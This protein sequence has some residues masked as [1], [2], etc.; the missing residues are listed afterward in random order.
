MA[1]AVMDV[2]RFELGLRIPEDVS[3][4]GFDDVP[5][6]AWPAYNLTTF[7]QRVNRMVAETVSTLIDR[8][9]A[10]NAE[11]RRVKIDGALI[12]RKSTRDQER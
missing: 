7:R 6:A 3:V 5:P 8:I 4:V 2:I 12:V 9:E 1:F 10:K 11:P